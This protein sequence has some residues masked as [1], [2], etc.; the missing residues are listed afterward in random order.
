[1]LNKNNKIVLLAQKLFQTYKWAHK[2]SLGTI[3][4]YIYI[5]FPP[6]KM[7]NQKPL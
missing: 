7:V 3:I 5:A 1:M 4:Q 2:N 6:Y